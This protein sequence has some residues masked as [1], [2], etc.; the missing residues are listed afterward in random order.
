MKVYESK[1]IRNVGVVGHGDSGKTR[2]PPGCS[3]PPEPRIAS[4]AS[5][6]ATRS[7][8]LT[9]RKSSARSR[10]LPP[11]PWPSGR[12]PR[13]TSWI[14]PVTTYLSTI[15][16]AR[17]SPPI[18]PW[19]WWTGWR[20]S[21]CKPR[22]SGRSRTITSSL[23]R[24]S[25]ISWIASAPISARAGQRSGDLRTHR[26]SHPDPDRHGARFQGRG[27]P[28]PH[29]GVHL[30]TG[31][32]RQRQG[33]RDSRRPRGCRPRRTK[34][35]WKWWRRATTRCME[36]FFAKGTLAVEHIVDGLKQGVRELRIFPVLCA[37]RAAQHRHRPDPELHRG[38]SARSHRAR[39]V[40][41]TVKGAEGRKIATA[42]RSAFVF[43]TTADPFAGRITYLQGDDRHH[44]ERR[45]PAKCQPERARAAGAPEHSPGQD[46]AAGDR[47]A[48]RRYRRGRQAEGH[49]DRR[50][51]G[52]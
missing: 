33:G 13:S 46:P 42:T 5:M 25:S 50:H 31:R 19:S 8:I 14:L 2:S 28:G 24:S 4:S 40:A 16:A 51:A 48:C 11:S 15:R 7:L 23:G 52:R 12:R 9:R 1:D 36:E 45:Q 49:P 27:R 38:E 26:R 47:T 41:A 3:S 30:H 35:W 10:S 32:R 6:K 18:P 43:K 17:W 37:V 20:A 22:R 39:D 34:P 44:Q 29:E 21:K